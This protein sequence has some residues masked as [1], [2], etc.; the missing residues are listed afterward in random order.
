[1]QKILIIGTVWPEPRSTAAGSRM[2]QIIEQ[3]QNQL[4]DVVFACSAAK[5]EFSFDLESIAVAT[6]AIELNNANFDDFIL[7]LNPSIVVF[8]RFMSE[9]Q[10]GWRVAEN[11]PNC[12]RILDTEDLHFVRKTRI[13]CF[14]IKKSVEINDYLNAELAQREIASIFRCDLSLIISEVEMEI[15]TS[16]FKIDS[17]ILLYVPFLLDNISQYDLDSFPSFAERKHFI[18]IG[19]FRHEPNWNSVLYLKETIW[20]M[21]KKQLPDAE[22]HIYGS[23][24][25]Q[26]AMN[27]NNVKEGFLVKGRAENAHDVIK[28]A[29]VLLA[30]IRFGAGIKGKLT[31][32]MIC[33]TPSVT[34]IEG[35]ESM[36]EN[37][38][39]SLLSNWNGEIVN[40]AI[41]FANAAVALYL[42]EKSWSTAQKNGINI[43]NNRFD[44]TY[45]GKQLMDTIL[46]TKN[47]LKYHR[48]HNFIGQMLQ[49][50]TL[51]S[52]KYMSKW[53][54]EKNRL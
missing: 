5:G 14:N 29:K 36:V 3:F 52:T 12:L 26:K 7:K 16:I 30:P 33:G 25:T 23:Y 4:F 11:L 32:A 38:S 19:N 15:L 1:M 8:D 27:L 10:F 22:L 17:R 45:F 13:E 51:K 41:D 42:K 44:K 49:M 9:E 24:V 50:Q 31:D 40:N 20:P 37:T 48:T 39:S 2:L 46:Q 53:I 47:N 34:T 6:V 28:K 43:V 18:T 35:A 21:I 54:E